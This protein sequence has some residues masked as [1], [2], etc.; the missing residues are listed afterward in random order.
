M[1]TLI[2]CCSGGNGS[3]QTHTQKKV[4]GKIT[5]NILIHDISKDVTSGSGLLSDCLK[6]KEFQQGR[7]LLHVSLVKMFLLDLELECWPRSKF[8][9][10]K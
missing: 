8:R 10:F 4:L 6:L 2:T 1:L 7:I 3:K 5:R 9:L